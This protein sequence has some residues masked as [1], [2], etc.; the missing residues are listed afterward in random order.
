MKRRARAGEVYITPE[1]N[2]TPVDR[3]R[4]FER[5]VKL[6]GLAS[7]FRYHDL[8]HTF[9]SRLAAAKVPLLQIQQLA[10]HS[11][12]KTTLRY[13]H[14]SPDHQRKAVEKVKF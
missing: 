4:W 1:R 5:V 8:R 6:A 11:D 9:C 3:R 10:G 13:A 12:F 2:V 14:L 7:K